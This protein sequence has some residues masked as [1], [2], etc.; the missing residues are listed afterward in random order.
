MI[1]VKNKTLF[2]EFLESLKVPSAPRMKGGTIFSPDEI[3][4]LTRYSTPLVYEFIQENETDREFYEMLLNGYM[5]KCQFMV[6]L[7]FIW[8]FIYVMDNI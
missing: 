5:K 4:Y 2:R 7:M 8:S 3:N 1:V 6:M